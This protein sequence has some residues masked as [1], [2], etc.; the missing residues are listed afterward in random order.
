M[1]LLFVVSYSRISVVHHTLTG[2][3]MQSNV[4]RRPGQRRLLRELGP[5]IHVL[6]LRGFIFF[7]TADRLLE[8][9]RSRVAATD[10]PQVRFVVL[11]FHRVTRIDSSAVLSLRRCRQMAEARQITLV[12]THL[13]TGI[14][15]QFE[16]GGLPAGDPAVRFFPDLDRGL[17]WCE[18]TLLEQAEVSPEEASLTLPAQLAEGGLDA[19]Q[20]ARLIGYLEKVEAAEGEYLVRQ[21]G[22]E[23]DLYLIEHGQVSVYRDC[24]GGV[25]LRLATLGPGTAIGE[26]GLYLRTGRT[27]SVVADSPTTAYRLTRVALARMKDE[28]PALAAAF[29]ELIARMLAERLVSKDLSL[30][31]LLR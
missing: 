9:I 4:E 10:L 30:E 25:R 19:A 20:G 16:V 14:R 21:G 2:A 22:E 24:E 15:R 11:D 6:E 8:Q 27:A 18:E 13:T 31:A 1:L 17:E 28:Q 12:L 3:E 26:L 7:G 5:Q 23:G 29:H